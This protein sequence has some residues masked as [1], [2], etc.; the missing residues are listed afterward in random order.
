MLANPTYK[1]LEASLRIGALTLAQWAQVLVAGVVAL[2][3]AVYVSPL[4]IGATIFVSVVLAG[5]PVALSCGAMAQE[6]SV[7]DAMRAQWAWFTSPRKYLPGPGQKATGY[8]TLPADEHSGEP[9]RPPGNPDAMQ[10]ERSFL[11]DL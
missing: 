1:Q 3:F 4:P 2:V 11:W 7:I 5:A 10:K 9:G 8:M 6:W